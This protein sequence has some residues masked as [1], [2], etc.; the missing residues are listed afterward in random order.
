MMGNMNSRCNS[1]NTENHTDFFLANLKLAKTKYGLRFSP[2]SA[3]L[4][5][6]PETTSS[7]NFVQQKYIIGNYD[8][9]HKSSTKKSKVKLSLQ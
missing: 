9:P 7:Q 8:G 4:S 5:T 2:R 3:T 1:T 6:G